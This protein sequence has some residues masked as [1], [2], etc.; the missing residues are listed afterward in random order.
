MWKGWPKEASQWLHVDNIGS[1][2]YSGIQLLQ[3]WCDIV[4][5]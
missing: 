4:K 5:R 3:L 1:E 2:L